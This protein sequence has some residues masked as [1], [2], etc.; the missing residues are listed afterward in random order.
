MKVEKVEFLVVTFL[1][2][3]LQHDNVQGVGVADCSIETQRLWPRRFQL[4]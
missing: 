4:G 3:P 2:H 1:P